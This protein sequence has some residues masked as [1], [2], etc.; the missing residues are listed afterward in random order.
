MV[1]T[2]SFHGTVFSILFHREFYSIVNESRGGTRFASLLTPLG[3]NS[4]MGD[5]SKPQVT[6]Q[7]A[8]DWKQ[9]DN[10]LAVK[11]EKSM[12]YLIKALG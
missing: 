7:S 6:Q 9:V 1:I 3:L 5:I 10:A 8:I 11:R 2:D 12:N 4:R